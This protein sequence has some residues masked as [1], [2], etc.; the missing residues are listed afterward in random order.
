MSYNSCRPGGSCDTVI[1]PA[2]PPT[3]KVSGKCFRKIAE[4]IGG[5]LVYPWEQNG[6][7]ER[8]GEVVN[9]KCLAMF[10]EQES[11]G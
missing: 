1:L 8:M 2:H 7:K 9:Q 11:K 4:T 6:C 3:S 10:Q 5:H